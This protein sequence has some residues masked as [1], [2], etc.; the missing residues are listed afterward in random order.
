M[1]A[2]TTFVFFDLGETLVDLTALVVCIAQHLRLDYPQLSGTADEIARAW[3]R[4]TSDSLPRT[5]GTPF[6]REIDVAATVLFQMVV[7]KGIPVTAQRAKEILRGA[8]DDFEQR[9]RL[10]AG[11][12]PAWLD[13]IRNLA[14][15]LGI[16]TDG[17]SVNVDRLVKRFRLADYFDAIV[18]SES[19]RAY[20]P[21]P[22]I[23]KAALDALGADPLQSIF[24]SDTPLDLRGAAAVGMRTAFLPRGLV[25]ESVDLPPGAL[26][27]SSPRGLNAILQTDFNV[28]NE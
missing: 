20:K 13:E 26:R 10:C 23:Y 16:V 27:L 4:R 15:G 2:R 9:V 11:V 5:E 22:R 7:A 17:D 14:A 3:I 8:W 18:T 12:S 6:V 25:S 1:G 24:V 19:V 21:S 28:G